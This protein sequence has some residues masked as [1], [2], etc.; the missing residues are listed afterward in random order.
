[1]LFCARLVSPGRYQQ[2]SQRGEDKKYRVVSGRAASEHELHW[3]KV[4]KTVQRWMPMDVGEKHGGGWRECQLSALWR[5][6]ARRNSARM[7][8][9]RTWTVRGKGG[10]GLLYP[11][12]GAWTSFSPRRLEGRGL[13]WK[14]RFLGQSRP[15]A[16]GPADSMRR[17]PRQTFRRKPPRRGILGLTS[18][19][20]RSKI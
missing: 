5:T 1:M 11:R 14:S 2:P 3:Q 18:T 13:D 4:T 10:L 12:R 19:K 17:S 15:R 9:K 7:V 8:R 16:V 6:I 20:N